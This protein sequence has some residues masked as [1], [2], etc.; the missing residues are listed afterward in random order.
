M[1]KTTLELLIATRE[2]FE[3]AGKLNN[4]QYEGVDNGI[5]CAIGCHFTLEEQ[6]ELDHGHHPKD[7][8]PAFYAIN[9]LMLHSPVRRAIVRTRIGSGISTFN[10]KR[11]QDMHDSK[12]RDE[13]GFQNFM[14]ELNEWIAQLQKRKGR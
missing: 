12:R 10:L 11:L 8:Y 6:R 9:N 14:T 2:K 13:T 1:Y 4:A 3:K 7:K 5:G